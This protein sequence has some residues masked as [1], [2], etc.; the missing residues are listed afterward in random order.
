MKT[1]AE[2][3]VEAMGSYAEMHAE[4]RRGSMDISDVGKE[5][6]VH[7]NGP[8]IAMADILGEAALDRHFGG[9]SRFSSNFT[10]YHFT[11]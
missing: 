1:H 11:I 7:W 5:A 6:M 2:G 8:P 10:F 3:V 4:Q 9:R